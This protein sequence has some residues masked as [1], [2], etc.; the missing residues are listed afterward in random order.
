MYNQEGLWS[1]YM[2]FSFVAQLR[3]DLHAY[4]HDVSLSPLVTI[5]YIEYI[6]AD[7]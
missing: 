2:I 5:L 7:L 6:V 3:E 1:V 4:Y